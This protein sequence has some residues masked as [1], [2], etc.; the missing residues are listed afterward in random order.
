MKAELTLKTILNNIFKQPLLRY[1]LLVS[2][3]IP[4]FFP[5]RSY[6]AVLP[7]FSDKLLYYTEEEAQK[8]ASHLE[9]ILV[10]VQNEKIIIS[11][12]THD[13]IDIVKKY[14][15]LERV[16][17]FS[18]EGRIVFSTEHDEIGQT[19][20]N[21][22]FYNIIATGKK[23]SK[24]ITKDNKTL[25][26][27]TVTRD[28]AEVYIPI[29]TGSKFLGAFELYYDITKRKED[30]DRLFLKE[31]FVGSFISLCMVG[32]IIF[33]VFLTSKALLEKKIAEDNLRRTNLD[34]E[35]LVDEKTS[36]L[37]I[38]QEA[39]I[40]SLAILA[41]N[42]DPDTGEHINRIRSLTHL[43]T[44]NLLK[45]TLYSEYL[46]SRIDYVNEIAVASILHD[47][48]KTAIPKEILSKPGK[49]TPE[50]FDLVK[51]HTTIAGE[52]LHQGNRLFVEKFGK[53]S[54]LA[55]A[56]DIALYHHE[57]WDGSGYPKGLKKQEIPLSARIVAIA[58]VYDALRSKRPYKPPWTHEK[59]M[60]LI[61][62]ESEKHFD[63]EL[64]RVFI[65]IEDQ[66]RQV[67]EQINLDE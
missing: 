13:Q 62:S 29:M 2:I 12:S 37:T 4:V 35:D 24:I 63:P 6:F 36:E 39:S 28:V 64:I 60:E 8:A 67:A 52:V 45:D 18:A 61:I 27:R 58:D 50:E 14:F 48:G 42:Y 49:L 32:I 54:Y 1:L 20:T 41:E 56:A 34:L 17:I 55:L 7:E 40:Q 9:A 47:I 26:G 16:K 5:L 25:E 15:Q 30:L 66:V 46:S 3:V 57:K 38:T 11:D 33:M 22:Y 43:L 23:Y 44:A 51:T 21:D 19:N 59:T 65:K 53:D 10:L 31:A